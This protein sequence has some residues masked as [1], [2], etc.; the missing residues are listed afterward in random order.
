MLAQPLWTMEVDMELM[1]I[2]YMSYLEHNNLQEQAGSRFPMDIGQ[3]MTEQER[4]N[5]LF[6]L[7]SF[8]IRQLN[9]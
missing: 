7:V 8:N 3:D 9:I 1:E 2:N 6:Y 5:I 4:K